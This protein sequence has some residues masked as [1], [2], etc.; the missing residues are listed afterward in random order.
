MGAPEWAIPLS[1]VDVRMT[2]TSSLN[3]RQIK[4]CSEPSDPGLSRRRSTTDVFEQ[5]PRCND[6]QVIFAK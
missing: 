2:S 6:H 3:R 1:R 5:L 4:G